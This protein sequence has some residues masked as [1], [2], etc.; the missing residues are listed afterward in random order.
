MTNSHSSKPEWGTRQFLNVS[1]GASLLIR[2]VG[3]ANKPTLLC[4]SRHGGNGLEFARLA[5]RFS[6]TFQVVAID[7]R[8]HG[9]SD[10]LPKDRGYAVQQFAAD[11]IEIVDQ[12][13]LKEILGVGVSMGGGML[14]L[15]N[16]QRPGVLKGA[17]VVDIGPETK[18][19]DDM[20]KAMARMHTLYG[21]FTAAYDTFDDIV[22]AWKK[23]QDD[24]WPNVEQDEWEFL[25]A[26]STTQGEDGKWTFTSDING[27][28]QRQPAEQPP[29]YWPSWNAL[30]QNVPT[31]LVYGEL[32]NLL[33]PEI[34]KKMTE[35]TPVE[36]VMA[37]GIGH[38]PII[39]LNPIRG[40]I[41]RFIL[42]HSQS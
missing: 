2:T 14:C 40:E 32:S 13:G 26:C 24:Q 18:P 17:V 23:I 4:L 41:E 38:H 6:D 21:L 19:P 39:D 35:G 22:E 33:S 10:F 42:Q 25:A 8:G 37:P 15:L 29:D 16:E 5:A 28:M 20:E 30:A 31:M 12:L 36:V 11:L 27:F 34:V 7:R 1:D 3:P 9:E